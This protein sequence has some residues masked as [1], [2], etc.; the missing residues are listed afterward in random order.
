MKIE[1]NRM[2]A[3]GTV[4]PFEGFSIKQYQKELSTARNRILEGSRVVK[5]AQ[6]RIEFSTAGKGSPVLFIHGAGGGYDMG[7]FFARQI[8]DD[9]FW[10]CPS[11]FGYLRTPIPQDSSF[12]SQADAYAALLDYLHIEKAAI[13]GLSIGGPSALLFA[14]RHPDRCAALVLVSA[15][16]KTMAKRPL[17][18]WFYNTLFCSDFIYWVVSHAFKKTL[19]K[20]FGVDPAVLKSLTQ[21]E[22]KWAEEALHIFHP[23]SRR[24]PGIRND[25]KASISDKQYDLHK[26]NIPTLILHATDDRLIDYDFARYAHARISKSKLVAIH[27]GGHLLLGQDKQHRNRVSGFLKKHL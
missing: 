24:Y 19:I 14:L 18:D 23:A 15:V 6:G 4:F 13:I 21:A 11:R 7:N 17:S 12:E 27:S 2:T 26:I 3:I 25:Q 20:K 10:I 9:F 5:T 22:K 1:I 16:S 8:G